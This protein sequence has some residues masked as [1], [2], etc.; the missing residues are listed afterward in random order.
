MCVTEI[1][2]IKF[3]LHESNK[4]IIMKIKLCI[5]ALFLITNVAHS[6][7]DISGHSEITP[8]VSNDETISSNKYIELTSGTYDY[9]SNGEK[10]ITLENNGILIV[11][12]GVTLD[13]SNL[14]VKDQSILY[15]ERGATVIVEKDFIVS[16]TGN[17]EINSLYF[18]ANLK[19]QAD[20]DSYV[21]GGTG[22]ITFSGSNSDLKVETGTTLCVGSDNPEYYDPDHPDF[23]TSANEACNK[24]GNTAQF[25][26]DL[27]VDLISFD[28][29]VASGAVT[30]NWAT[31]TEINASHFIVFS[32]ED[33]RNWKELGEVEAG[34]NTNFRQNYSFTDTPSNSSDIVFYK[35]LQYD[36]DGQ[37]ET[38][39]PLKVNFNTTKVLNASVYPNP[40]VN[41]LN[42]KIDGL[43]SETQLSLTIVDKLGKTICQ[44]VKNV[45]ANS[46]IY[47]LNHLS[48]LQPGHYFLIISSGTQ[49]KVT[50]FIKQ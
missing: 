49:T 13:V 11:R 2:T 35:L 28:A 10:S 8:D 43:S 22:R 25:H 48:E 6:Q 14:T 47:S 21:L 46:L 44:E 45:K 7:P 20:D 29:S 40:T 23:G 32:S 36:F 26:A 39:G 17:S 50:P 34:G 19:I 16:S 5:L 31:A 42:L 4:I 1:N 15:I 12:D 9:N 30:L 37:N 3:F 18:Y 33:N 41:R 24:N 38:F 27:P